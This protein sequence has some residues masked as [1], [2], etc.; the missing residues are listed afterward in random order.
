[1]EIRWDDPVA[2]AIGTAIR[3]GDVERL[4]QFLDEN[5]ELAKARIVDDRGVGRTL[6]HIAADWPGHF[7]NGAATVAMLIAAGADPNAVVTGAPSAET[8]L[9]WAASSNDVAVLD[10]LLDGGA[11]IESSGAIFTG[12]TP[13]SDAVVFAQWNAAR[14]LLERGARTTI[15]QSA[16]LGLVDRIQHDITNAFWHA[17]R[18]GQLQAAQYLFERG[19]DVHWVGHDKKTPLDVAIESGNDDLVAWLKT[20]D[21]RRPGG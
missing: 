10:A 16:A 18:G 19:A 11:D 1:M 9:H 5:R 8:P 7:P 21:S 6:L 4:Q 20:A 2:V 13:M 17:C 15:W 3:S 12:G 14:R